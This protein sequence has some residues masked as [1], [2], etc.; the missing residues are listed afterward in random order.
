MSDGPPRIISTQT[1]AYG[2][3]PRRVP[4]RTGD[5]F[6]VREAA[7]GAPRG[8]PVGRITNLPPSAADI[9]TTQ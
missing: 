7:E 9:G 6:L 5:S 4:E 1:T 3:A 2:A 8:A